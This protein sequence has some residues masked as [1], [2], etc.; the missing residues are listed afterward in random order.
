MQN[1]IPKNIQ[2]LLDAKVIYYNNTSFIAEDPI[3]IPHR[4]TKQQDIEIS[5]FFAATL[6]WGLR[7]TIINKCSELLSIMDNAPYDFIRYHTNK[8]LKQISNFKHRTFNSTDTL[9]FIEFLKHH[10]AQYESL[11][12]AFSKYLKTNDATIENGLIGFRN[13]FFSLEIYPSRTKKHIATPALNSAC[14]RLNMYLRWMVRKDE[15]GVDFGLWNSI[16]TSQL[17][18][19]LDVHVE[20]VARTL[21]LITRKQCD[22]KTA[23]ELT[24][25]LKKLDKNDPV[26]YDFALFSMGVVEK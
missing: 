12:F 23:L 4:F 20:R 14:K 26:K 15:T 8:D 13:Y 6:A 25:N 21:N 2:Q 11:E 3:S 10:Y 24:Q 9:Y 5:G 7:K 19:P 22:W 1:S 16:K 18:C 17:I